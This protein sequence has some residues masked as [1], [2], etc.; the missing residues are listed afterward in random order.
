MIY[1][2]FFA[3]F[4]LTVWDAVDTPCLSTPAKSTPE[5]YLVKIWPI[6]PLSSEKYWTFHLPSVYQKIQ[7]NTGEIISNWYSPMNLWTSRRWCLILSQ[8]CHSDSPWCLLG[9]CQDRSNPWWFFFQKIVLSFLVFIQFY[10]LFI[11]SW[12][13]DV[14]KLKIP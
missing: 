4:Q 1:K 11:V 2:I 6:R 12:E 9:P 8:W 14:V 3:V 13:V 5:S 10:W 7:F